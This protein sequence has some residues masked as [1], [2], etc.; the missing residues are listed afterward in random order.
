MPP[1]AFGAPASTTATSARMRDIAAEVESVRAVMHANI[2]SVLQRGER[3]DSLVERSDE[4]Q[5]QAAQFMSRSKQLAS[6][7][8]AKKSKKKMAAHEFE[9]KAAAMMDDV[10]DHCFAPAP[11]RS[12]GGDAPA[13][14]LL[15]VLPM[16]FGW[17]HAAVNE[18]HWVAHRNMTVPTRQSGIITAPHDDC[19]TIDLLLIEGCLAAADRNVI[20]R[21]HTFGCWPPAQ[22]GEAVATITV[23][24]DAD[25]KVVF[26]ITPTDAKGTPKTNVAAT[27]VTLLE[28]DC[29]LSVADIEALANGARKEEERRE[30]GARLTGLPHDATSDTVSQWFAALD[31]LVES[32]DVDRCPATGMCLGTA[33]LTFRTRHALRRAMVTYRLRAPAGVLLEPVDAGDLW[34]LTEDAAIVHLTAMWQGILIGYSPDKA[35]LMLEIMQILGISRCL[36]SV[37]EQRGLMSEYPPVKVLE[38][39]NALLVK[40]ARA[41]AARQRRPSGLEDMSVRLSP[42]GATLCAFLLEYS[43]ISDGQELYP[44][45]VRQRPPID[46][47]IDVDAVGAIDD[48]AAWRGGANFDDLAAATAQSVEDVYACSTRSSAASGLEAHLASL[49][50][51]HTMYEGLHDQRDELQAIADNI[52]TTSSNVH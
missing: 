8:S 12:R 21:R 13:L 37:V 15:D 35:V 30:R 5:E 14:L 26:T 10:V 16:G 4:L 1:M 11:A 45:T 23:D 22:R 29:Y 41:R 51:I 38:D 31:E 28:S 17:A 27:H 36:R 50:E 39:A 7:S 46:F 19:A 48:E 32:V 24:I 47:E 6:T 2:D 34:L 20:R 33:T 42:K 40:F 52:R 9:A 43:V 25:H 49:Q 3:L 18:S 44:Y